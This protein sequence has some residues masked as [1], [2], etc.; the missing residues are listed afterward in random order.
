[1]IWFVDLDSL[2]RFCAGCAGSGAR[3][4]DGGPAVFHLGQPADVSFSVPEVF[5]AIFQVMGQAGHTGLV[6]ATVLHMGRQAANDPDAAK[7]DVRR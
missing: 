7:H 2:I 4:R 1:L 3:E 6:P 5:D